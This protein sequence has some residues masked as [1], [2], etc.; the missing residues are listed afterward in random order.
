MAVF[1]IIQKSQLEG[2]NRLDAE[3]YQPEYLELDKVWKRAK[4]ILSDVADCVSGFAF[5]SEDLIPNEGTPVI[6]MNNLTTGPFVDLQE[7]E[8]VIDERKYGDLK[9]FIVERNDIL[10]GLT[11]SLGSIALYLGNR[12]A[13]VNQRILRVR[14]SKIKPEVLLAILRSDIFR[15]YLERVGLG[16]VQPNVRPK[17]AEVFPIV[18][19]GPKELVELEETMKEIVYHA[20][21]V[22]KLLERVN[23]KVLEIANPTKN[24]RFG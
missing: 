22:D 9:R 12:P 14:A 1:S 23:T 15:K 10:V 3:Y 2:A 4:L 8:G 6:K 5:P 16:G 19:M 17:D 7:Y 13:Y 20:L 18:E 11:G 21:S 24:R